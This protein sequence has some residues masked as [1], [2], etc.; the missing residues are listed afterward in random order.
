MHEP[1]QAALEHQAQ[2]SIWSCSA[3]P[4]VTGLACLELK[5]PAA[6][7]KNEPT[8]GD[9]ALNKPH[10]SQHDLKSALK[11]DTMCR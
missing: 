4:K 8:S 11:F 6:S 2:A 10:K 1:E 3:L 7:L 5:T 9:R